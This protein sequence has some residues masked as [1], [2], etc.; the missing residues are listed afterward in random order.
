M[1]Y[2]TPQRDSASHSTVRQLLLTFSIGGQLGLLT[3]LLAA[4]QPH[5]QHTQHYPHHP[6]SAADQSR[7][8]PC[9]F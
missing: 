7:Y 4:V 2:T 6:T 5:S 9:L 3:S 1:K 8:E